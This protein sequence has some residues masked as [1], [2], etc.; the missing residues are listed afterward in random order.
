MAFG[1]SRVSLRARWTI[2]AVSMG[3]IAIVAFAVVMF[4]S[5]IGAAIT[6][7][8][9]SQIAG[10]AIPASAGQHIP[11][12]LR[13]EALNKISGLPLYFE[14]NQGQVNS[15]VRYLARS[16]R[17]S[18]FLTDDAAVFSL[19]GGELNKGTLPNGFLPG[20]TA[21]TK[22]TQSAVRVRLVGANPHRQAEGLERLQGRVNYLI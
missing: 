22:Q 8:P 6:A 21:E 14:K 4:G 1:N 3:A 10:Q 12:E 5:Q 18:L 19:I 9:N 11:E 2:A 15:S 17:Y 16:G 7:S 20:T 13:K